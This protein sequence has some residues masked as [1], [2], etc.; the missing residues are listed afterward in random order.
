MDDSGT[1]L[2]Q[3]PI[4][5]VEIDTRKI[6]EQ[7]PWDANSLRYG[8][9]D[10]I[11]GFLEVHKR[12]NPEEN[13]KFEAPAVAFTE[14]QRAVISNVENQ[15]Q[16]LIYLATDVTRLTMVQE[17]AGKG[18]STILQQ[19]TSLLAQLVGELGRRLER[20]QS[21]SAELHCTRH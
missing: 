17:K 1:T 8:S 11:R 21:T 14:D 19:I 7:Y 12:S 16:P 10:N 9:Y 15:L 6:N 2:N 13:R 18:K 4:T 20:L 3:Q 5:A